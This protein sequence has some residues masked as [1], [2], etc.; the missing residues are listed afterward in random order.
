[1]MRSRKRIFP[2]WLILLIV[3]VLFSVLVV[4]L[5]PEKPK[6]YQ[7]Y[8][9]NSPSPTGV[10][11]FYTYLQKESGAATH[12]WKQSTN[13]LPDNSTGE[14]MIMVEPN[15]PF[16]KVARLKW[17]KWM[18]KGN[19]ILLMVSDPKDFFNLQATYG[20]D[21][22]DKETQISGEKALSGHYLGKVTSS[23]RL[24][25][26]NQDDILLKDDQGILSLARPYDNGEL[27]V[28]LEPGWLTNDQILHGSTLQPIIKMINQTHP[29]DIW[30]N[31]AIHGNVEQN[32][33]LNL[34]PSWF[35]ILIAQGGI[36]LLLL[37]WLN[38]KR[39]GPI[40]LPRE[41]TVRINNE[42]LR[43]TAAWYHRGG[44]YMESLLDQ[45]AYLRQRL[46]ERF[47]IS[48]RSTDDAMLDQLKKRLPSGK[49]TEWQTAWTEWKQ[50]K[51]NTGLSKKA[52]LKWADTF[53]N[54]L[55]EVN[56]S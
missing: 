23:A 4:L 30:F 37:L 2:L 22:N 40:D 10:K 16:T 44:L 51:D 47:H 53:H 3:I 34:F 54:L 56:K 5:T 32:R 14:L 18:K 25:S 33:L 50:L 43:A 11:A 12:I 41:A 28:I 19:T 29:H 26:K 52:Y 45:E 9:A 42:R 17:E 21:V 7:P 13:Q 48:A 36:L 20:H 38:G 24:I 46:E 55:N 1:M 15:Q 35:V 39:F 49:F 31:E 6:T 8:L 27:I